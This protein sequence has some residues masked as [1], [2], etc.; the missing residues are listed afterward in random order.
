MNILLFTLI[1]GTCCLKAS[2]DDVDI[3]IKNLPSKKKQKCLIALSKK[4]QKYLIDLCFREDDAECEDSAY[5]F[6]E[7]KAVFCKQCKILYDGIY[8]EFSEDTIKSLAR[9]MTLIPLQEATKQEV[10]DFLKEPEND[11]D[12]DLEK[13]ESITDILKKFKALTDIR[14][15]IEAPQA[16]DK[17]FEHLY[18]KILKKRKFYYDNES[19]R[20][21]RLQ[22]K[23]KKLIEHNGWSSDKR[24]EFIT[25][26]IAGINE[27][28]NIAGVNEARKSLENKKD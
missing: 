26:Y 12:M 8:T 28:R 17:Y 11:N 18:A 16:S 3:D 21:P 24:D 6:K 25:A 15:L 27:A 5:Y 14:E 10:E 2:A 19:A 23:L 22:P 9:E 20:V 4:K 1:F 7:H 13:Q